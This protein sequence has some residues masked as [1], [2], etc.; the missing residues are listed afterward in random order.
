MPGS[1]LIL[2]GYQN[3]YYSPSGILHGFLEDSGQVLASLKQTVSLLRL[4]APMDVP[5]IETPITF[6]AD[7]EELRQ[8]VGILAAIRE[9]RAFQSGAPGARQVT[10]FEAFGDRIRTVPG[11]RGLNAF[12]GTD[13]EATLRSEGA[14]DLYFCGSVASICIDSSGRYA[15]ERG[16][17]VTV[18]SDC[19]T[20]RTRVEHDF[21]VTSIFPLYAR[22]LNAQEAAARIADRELV[23][24]GG[25]DVCLPNS[26]LK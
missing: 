4:L 1:A 3:D 5:F 15:A 16:F 24:S 25:R 21:Y 11:K 18:V 9:Y 22:V 23:T 17:D 26:K 12:V 13:L 6:T 2:I 8:P 10:E 20:G 19:V 14:T 7:Y